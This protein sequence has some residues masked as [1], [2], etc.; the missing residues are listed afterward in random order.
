MLYIFSIVW[1]N[2]KI[3]RVF[4]SIILFKFCIARSI[5]EICDRKPFFPYL[6]IHSIAF[7]SCCWQRFCIYFKNDNGMVWTKVACKFNLDF[8][9]C[10][11]WRKWHKT[12]KEW[13]KR[14][15]IDSWER[16]IKSLKFYLLIFYALWKNFKNLKIEKTFS[17]K[18][19]VS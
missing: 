15:T 3:Y 7:C 8:G 9:F 10:Q 6:G 18:Y 4:F 19:A 11:W 17:L 16:T 12:E 14:I 5:N 2:F 13:K 1:W